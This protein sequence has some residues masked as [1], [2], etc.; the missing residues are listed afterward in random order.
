MGG[1]VGA[2]VDLGSTSVHLLVGRI[3]DHALQALADE[4]D[5]LGLGDAAAAGPLDDDRLG[6]LLA[7]L[8]RFAATAR[9]LGADAP[10]FVATE[11]LRRLANAGRVAHAIEAATAV[12]LHVL[13][14]E[15]EGLLVLIG[16]TG[17]RPVERELVVVD[18]GGGS[19]EFVS[20]APGRPASATGVRVGAARLTGRHLRADPPTAADVE[21]LRSAA[22]AAVAAAPAAAPAELV[23][24]GGTASNLLRLVPA[25]AT[26]RCLTPGRVAET[27]A[28]LTAESAEVVAARHGIRAARA[29]LLPA[30]AAIVEAIIDRYGVG[31][32]RVSEAGIR[33][34]TIRA[35]AHGGPG[36]RDRLGELAHGWRA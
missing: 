13:S 2:A 29:R 33:E 28:A 20:V 10:T 35:V 5:F 26:S 30:G 15:E 4:S 18:I 31:E 17:G 1:T 23:I 19:S 32:A 34:G 11:P 27:L 16:V 21:E 6:S 25:A 3:D 8:R 36:W 24:V 14:H 22:R 12:P 7:T 9:G